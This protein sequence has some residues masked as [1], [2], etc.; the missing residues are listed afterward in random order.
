MKPNTDKQSQEIK[1]N[2]Y[3]MQQIKSFYEPKDS[4]NNVYVSGL[5]EFHGEDLCKI[6]I[7][8]R[9]SRLKFLKDQ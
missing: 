6:L 5:L 7:L 8:E 3:K 1:D 4:R 9:E 2:D